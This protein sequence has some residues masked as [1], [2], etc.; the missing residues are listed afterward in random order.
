VIPVVL[1]A[2]R[3]ALRAGDEAFCLL[4]EVAGRRS[5][6]GARHTVKGMARVRV[7]SVEI[8]VFHVVVVA[9]RDAR[10]GKRLTYKRGEL[11]ATHGDECRAFG[12]LVTFLW[13]GR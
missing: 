12:Q 6:S 11:Y 1:P 5:R 3:V 10:P 13:G 4:V 8:D 7:E 2:K 9:S